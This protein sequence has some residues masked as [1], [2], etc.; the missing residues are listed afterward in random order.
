[1]EQILPFLAQCMFK[2]FHPNG[3]TIMKVRTGEDR[4]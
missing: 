4:L 3:D 1:M 2:L